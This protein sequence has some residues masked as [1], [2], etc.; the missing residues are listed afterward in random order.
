MAN[1]LFRMVNSFRDDARR[2]LPASHP[3][4]FIARGI[5]P[6]NKRIIPLQFSAFLAGA[7]TR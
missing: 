1:I 4:Q 5:V 2:L 6:G 3:I 7:G